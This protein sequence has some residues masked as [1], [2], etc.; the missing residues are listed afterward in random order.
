VL[1]S[2]ADEAIEQLLVNCVFSREIWFRLFRS[3]SFP[4]V[5]PSQD[6]VWPDWWIRARKHISKDQRK[7]FDT[8]V[9]LTC[10]L[11]WKECNNRVFNHLSHRPASLLPKIIDEYR[12][13][14]ATGYSSLVDWL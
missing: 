10:W 9:V 1:C 12:Q 2:Q 4:G 6:D 14:V 13:W 3:L 11:L 5:T 7:G 8:L